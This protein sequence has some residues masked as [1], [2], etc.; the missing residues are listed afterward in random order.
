M[1]NTNESN[2]Q[3]SVFYKT[4]KLDLLEIHLIKCSSNQRKHIVAL[5]NIPLE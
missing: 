5:K 2:N 3:L 1:I 4:L